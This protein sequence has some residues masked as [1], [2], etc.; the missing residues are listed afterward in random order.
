M[1]TYGSNKEQVFAT[2][3]DEVSTFLNIINGIF[4]LTD[5][6]KKIFLSIIDKINERNNS[7]L[8]KTYV[9]DGEEKEFVPK[10][11]IDKTIRKDVCDN[12]TLS[13]NTLNNY[14]TKLRKKKAL[15]GNSINTMFT[16]SSTVIKIVFQN[17]DYIER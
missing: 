2:N 10:Y 1:A 12:L 15:L 4:G 5:K 7:L 6:E 11:T 17:H 9:E 8:G 3:V 14:L 16:G 13:E